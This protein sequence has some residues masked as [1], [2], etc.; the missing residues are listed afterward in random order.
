[1]RLK[2]NLILQITLIFWTTCTFSTSCFAAIVFSDTMTEGS[3]TSLA[4]HTPDTGDSWTLLI[5]VGSGT[6]K[7][8]AASDDLQSENGGASD[9]ALYTANLANAYPSP[10]YEISVTQGNGD[11][12]DD[13]NILAVRIQ[14]ADN[15]YAVRWN[16][17]AGQIYENVAG[18][19]GTL[20]AATAGV[21]DGSI[22]TLRAHANTITFLDDGVVLRTVQ[23]TSFAAAGKA[24]VGMG[25]VILADDDLAQQNFDNIE[26]KMGRRLI[27]VT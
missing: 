9:G 8:K 7:V 2:P 12:D 10:N 22:V 23:D 11:T 14:D 24:G 1:M 27:S 3:D 6:L 15:M 17:S 13:V 19:W 5:S 25:S 4:A 20:G 18:T 21:A 16:E 26:V